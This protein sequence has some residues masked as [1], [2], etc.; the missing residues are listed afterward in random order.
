MSRAVTEGMYE[1]GVDKKSSK[2]SLDEINKKWGLNEKYVEVRQFQK[3]KHLNGY[4]VLRISHATFF[5]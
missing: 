2:G 4:L 5:C 1:L 3:S